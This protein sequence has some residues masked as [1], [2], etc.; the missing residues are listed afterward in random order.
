MTPVLYFL[1]GLVMGYILWELAKKHHEY[2]KFHQKPS[3]QGK[4]VV[5]QYQWGNAFKYGE[6]VYVK[7]CDKEELLEGK[8][9]GENR[10]FV[11]VEVRFFVDA[12]PVCRT[13]II[14]AKYEMVL[15]KFQKINERRNEK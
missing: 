1:L 4:I 9:V 6:P 5:P 14:S 15:R 8:V 2:T 7:E 11:A 13:K 3:M 12:S 10:D